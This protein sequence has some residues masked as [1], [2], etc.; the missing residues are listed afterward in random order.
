M[1]AEYGAPVYNL[2]LIV[3][4]V[5]ELLPGVRCYVEQTGGGIATIYLGESYCIG[6]SGDPTLWPCA[7][8]NYCVEHDMLVPVMAGPGHFE[9]PGFSE[10]RSYVE[11]FS[12]GYDAFDPLWAEGIPPCVDGF[13]LDPIDERAVAR[14]LV[15]FYRAHPRVSDGSIH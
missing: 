15:E 13:A 9:G 14:R 6:D 5:R 8:G 4:H 7:L 3:A 1:S 2:E 10:G 12:L 11:E